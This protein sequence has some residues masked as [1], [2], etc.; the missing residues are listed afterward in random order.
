[1]TTNAKINTFSNADPVDL[2]LAR[3]GT[4]L[5]QDKAQAV[6]WADSNGVELDALYH[7]GR[8]DAFDEIAWLIKERRASRREL[9]KGLDSG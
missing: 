6:Q 7:A 5:E 3:L 8:A 4:L 1:M 9:M 2:E